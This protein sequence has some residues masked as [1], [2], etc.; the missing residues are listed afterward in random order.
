M[1]PSLRSKFNGIHKRLVEKGIKAI[2]VTNEGFLF[3]P[4]HVDEDVRA[5]Y[6]INSFN[7][8]DTNYDDEFDDECEDFL[9]NDMYRNLKEENCYIKTQLSILQ[10]Q[11]HML[12]QDY[13]RLSEK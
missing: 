6:I 1:R 11:V 13:Q 4:Y 8:E 10:R 7:D 9:S 5:H 12:R 3:Y 2:S